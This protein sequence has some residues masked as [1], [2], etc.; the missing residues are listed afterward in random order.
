MRNAPKSKYQGGRRKRGFTLLEVMIAV[1]LLAMVFL[2]TAFIGSITA[3]QIKALYG[4]VRTLHRAHLVLERIRYKLMMG[5]VG[6]PVVKDDG[7][8]LEFVNPLLN[9]SVSAFKF[10]NGKVYYYADKTE[11]ASTPGQGIG[12]VHDLRFEVLGPGNAVRVSV[13]TLENVTW[14]LAKPYTLTTEIT[15]RN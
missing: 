13:T 15:L 10:V 8:T 7:R 4:D 6:S 12:L 5:S 2:A 1:G 9:G 11:A 14:K 3:K